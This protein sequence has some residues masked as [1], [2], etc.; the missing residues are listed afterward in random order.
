MAAQA[1]GNRRYPFA[2]A[3]AHDPPTPVSKHLN[4]NTWKDVTL[5][6]SPQQR[7]S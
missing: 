3:P 6:A 7:Q 5:A 4:S 2:R 1:C